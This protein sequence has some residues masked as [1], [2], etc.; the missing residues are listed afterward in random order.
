MRSLFLGLDT[1]NYKTSAG[2][3]CP[4]DGTFR[5]CGKLLEVPLKILRR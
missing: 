4:E 3:Y 5:A 1:S 2:L